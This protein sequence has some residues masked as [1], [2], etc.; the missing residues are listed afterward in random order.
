MKSKIVGLIG[1]AILASCA[2]PVVE[3]PV[4]TGGSRADASVEM[5]YQT[6]LYRPVT[7]NWEAALSSATQRCRAWGYSRADAFEGTSTT[8]NVYDAYLGCTQST[9]TRTYQC[10]G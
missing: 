10:L 1:F 3:S 5:S 7:P 8:C 2:E 6:G 4:A 9:V